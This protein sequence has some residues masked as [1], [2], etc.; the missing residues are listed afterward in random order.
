MEIRIRTL[1]NRVPGDNKFIAKY[2]FIELNYKKAIIPKVPEPLAL[3]YS[4]LNNTDAI[5]KSTLTMYLSSRF[6]RRDIYVNDVKVYKKDRFN[7]N[8]F[9]PLNMLMFEVTFKE[10][11]RLLIP[12]YL[13]C[14]K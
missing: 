14:D 6:H 5:G 13:L 10:L 7:S 9:K 8:P 3:H 2:E 1:F 12:T 11:L 4:C